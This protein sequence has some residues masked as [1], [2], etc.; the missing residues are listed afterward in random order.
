[1]M[2]RVWGLMYRN[3]IF[4]FALHTPGCSISTQSR[5]G[6]L[7][8]IAYRCTIYPRMRTCTHAFSSQATIRNIQD[9]PLPALQPTT[10]AFLPSDTAYE[11]GQVINYGQSES[12]GFD[13][14][15]V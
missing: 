5:R 2:V 11:I 4:S 1:M 8:I 10:V 3:F 14:I 7:S 15:Q 12:L 13:W 6:K 9:N